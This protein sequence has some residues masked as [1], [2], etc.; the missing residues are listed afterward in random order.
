M[1]KKNKGN[2]INGWLS[3]DK[4]AGMTSTQVIGAVRRVLHPKKI[5][6][7]GTLDPLATGALPI[8]L[9]EATKTV[10]WTQDYLKTYLFDVRF[11]E[12]RATD[13]A[14]GEI[15]GTSETRPS[16]A[17]ITAAL[18][19]FIGDVEQLPPR[20]SAIK[21]AGQRA[22]DLARAGEDVDL[23]PREVYIESLEVV[24]Y[25]EGDILTLRCVCGKGTYVRSIA[26][27]LALKLNSAGYVSALRREN[28]GPFD[29]E[30]MISLEFL[31]E[32]SNKDALADIL[33]PIETALDDIPALDLRGEEAARLKSGQK[34]SFV[35][36]ID[37]DRLLHSGLR[38][39]KG[40]T[41][42]AVAFV[43]GRLVAL[44]DVSGAIVKP[45][46]VF[47]I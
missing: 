10:S 23:K 22:Y 15:I 45:D 7:A 32:M 9:G 25:Y 44:V 37:F 30:N 34:L 1:S 33:L 18:P 12:F 28:V 39:E 3:I 27:D 5:G 46:R 16:L 11:G 36:R 21:I 13:D 35:S 38:C 20:F 29:K 47:N 19:A 42:T 26:R 31:E 24:A 2:D 43:N 17:E 8:A 40:E 14:E 6:H 41:E 4:P